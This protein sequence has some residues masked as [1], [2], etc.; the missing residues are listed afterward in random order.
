MSDMSLEQVVRRRLKLR[1]LRIL[2]EVVESGSMGKAAE[3]LSMSQPVVS[4][5]V[6]SLEHTLGAKLLDRTARGVEPT[7]SG[8]I[9]IKCGVSVFDD[10]RQA[11]EEIELAADPTAGTV[12]IG[13]VEPEF[14]GIVSAV[15]DRMTARY[16]RIVFHISAVPHNR[17]YQELEA[18]SVDLLLAGMYESEVHDHVQVEQLYSEPVLVTV[19]VSSPWA[20]RRRVRLADLAEEPWALPAPGAFVTEVVARAFREINLPAP[21]PVAVCSSDKRISLLASGRLVTAVPG[22]MVRVSGRRLSIKA[23]PIDLKT[24]LRS[25]GIFTL[26]GRSLS[27]VAQLFIDTARAIAKPLGSGQAWR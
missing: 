23:L 21:S 10:L 7:T 12:R 2:M 22:A 18:R 26:K 16:P 15:I 11:I 5:A 25:T 9:A 6:A 17:R 27:P 13:C 14:A 24:E 20:K 4:K 8:R 1:E 3:R 19:G